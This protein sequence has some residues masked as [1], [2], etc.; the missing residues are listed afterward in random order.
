VG[1]YDF[2]GLFDAP[3]RLA[4][5]ARAIEKSAAAHDA[6]LV[7][8]WLG[9]LPET[10]ERIREL[11]PIAIGE[12]TSQPGGPAGARFEQARDRLLEELGVSVVRAFVKRVTARAAG[13]VV[14]LAGGEELDADAVL[15][16]V[17]GV[18]AG[19]IVLFEPAPRGGGR[20]FVLS[21]DAPAALELDGRE[22]DAPSTLFGLDLQSRGLGVLERVGIRADGP[23]VR[24]QEGLFCAGDVVAARPRTALEAARG[25]I[26]AARAA[27]GVTR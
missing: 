21:L 23:R 16:A 27:T 8:P 12:T 19:G 25:G 15:L 18:V 3:E 17:G 24:G 9:L 10:T 6:L 5:L 4:K 2:A 1:A 22:L 11:V 13:F 14:E 26:A 20:S 7:G